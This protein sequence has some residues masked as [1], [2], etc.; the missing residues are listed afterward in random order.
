MNV[1]SR[2]AKLI[3]PIHQVNSFHSVAPVALGQEL[4]VVAHAPDRSIEAIEHTE[5][6]I[7]GIMW[8]P[9]RRDSFLQ[10]EM[11]LFQEFFA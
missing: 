7:L 11:D 6:A 1:D 4:R 3:S 5:K 9:E 2:H 10:A 8:H